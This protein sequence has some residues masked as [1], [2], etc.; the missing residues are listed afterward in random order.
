MAVMSIVAIAGAAASIAS[1][2]A[3]ASQASKGAGSPNTAS[4]SRK[5]AKAAAGALPTQRALAAAEQ[6]GKGGVAAGYKQVKPTQA[7]LAR[8]KQARN[9]E[10]Q[11]AYASYNG[12][13]SKVYTDGK[14]HLVDKQL[15]EPNFAGY[16]SADITAELARR[17]A[18]LQE[19]LGAKYGTQFA[20]EA[21]KEA[22]LADPEGTRARAVENELIQRQLA[23]P[24]TPVAGQLD[25]Q[26][27]AQ[28]Q[29][30]A[31][32]D[33]MTQ[34]LLDTAV[35]QAA[36]DR[37]GGPS[38]AD[39]GAIMSTGAEGAA[40]RQAA[41]SK[42]QGFLASGQTPEDVNYRREQQNIS[43]LGSFVSGTT[44]ESQFGGLAAARQGA[45]PTYTGQA[46]PTMPPGVA[47][48]GNQYA[49]QGWQAGLNAKQNQPNQWLAGIS[50]LMQLGG[51][52][53]A[54]A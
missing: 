24:V 20:E 29:A 52:I 41:M 40:R 16:G 10:A 49:M 48:A 33:P 5:V 1:V 14:G 50:S 47:Q 18:D 53:G 46:L 35:A 17:A 27:R 54:M 21:A 22:A 44:P 23:A 13:F 4:A 43:N 42:A 31:G 51:S 32:F 15:A 38:A 25:E 45:T 19:K 36:Q 30:G 9:P 37:G 7:L 26:I 11:A 39:V 34:D 3:Q 6:A 8:W 2:A 28:Q 12:D